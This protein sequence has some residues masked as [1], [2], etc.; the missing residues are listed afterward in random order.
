MPPEPSTPAG[1]TGGV[2]SGASAPCGAGT[3]TLSSGPPVAATEDPVVALRGGDPGRE[4]YAYGCSQDVE[5]AAGID[6]S[7]VVP[8]LM[9]G[10]FQEAP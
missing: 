7:T 8:V 10:A 2:A 9:D 5:V 6:A 4:P 3:R 1:V